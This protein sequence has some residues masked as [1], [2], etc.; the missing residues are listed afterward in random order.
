[1]AKTVTYIDKSGGKE[2]LDKIL[3]TELSYLWEV[4]P[5]DNV[6]Y[7]NP[8]AH[9]KKNKIQSTHGTHIGQSTGAKEEEEAEDDA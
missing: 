8:N 7:N 1:M 9:E 4:V 3:C 2:S 6:K 5:E